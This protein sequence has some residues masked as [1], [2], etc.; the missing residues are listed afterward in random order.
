VIIEK[1]GMRIE[2]S[3]DNASSSANLV[4]YEAGPPITV[5]D[6]DAYNGGK[7]PLGSTAPTKKKKGTS[8]LETLMH[9]IKAN[10]GTGVLAMPLA[11]KNGGLVLSGISLW[12]MGFICIHCMHILLDCYKYSMAKYVK[13]S[14]KKKSSENIGYEDVVQMIAEEKYPPGSKWPRFFKVLVSVVS[15]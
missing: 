12:I 10:I 8:N 6:C 5:D 3:I 11:F 9:M 4:E 14:D 13:P 7:A 1:D 2:V 15:F